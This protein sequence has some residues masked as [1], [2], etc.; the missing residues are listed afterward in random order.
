MAQMAE[1]VPEIAKSGRTNLGL[2]H[3]PFVNPF[4]PI[5]TAASVTSISKERVPTATSNHEETVLEENKEP[6]MDDD[7]GKGAAR[8][9]RKRVQQAKSAKP[10]SEPLPV[11]KA[12]E[13]PAE[14]PEE[15]KLEE[16][17]HNEFLAQ[18]GN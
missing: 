12:E 16:V 3:H 7:N 1:E 2:P 11:K 17:F 8:R 9:R 6:P 4:T 5:P 14:N 10:T 15:K 13:I 18:V